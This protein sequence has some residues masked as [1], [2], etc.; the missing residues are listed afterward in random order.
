MH[1]VEEPEEE[2]SEDLSFRSAIESLREEIREKCRS[3][4]EKEYPGRKAEGEY[5]RSSFKKIFDK[6]V[7]LSMKH[8]PEGT[9]TYNLVGSFWQVKRGLSGFK[10]QA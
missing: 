2:L 4:E 8:D 5:E 3:L 9:W 7:S 10:I 6:Y 1:V